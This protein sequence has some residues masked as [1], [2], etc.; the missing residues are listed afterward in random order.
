M[1]GSGGGTGVA[2]RASSELNRCDFSLAISFCRWLMLALI[3]LTLS[4]S[5]LSSPISIFSFSSWI[6]SRP[7]TICFSRSVIAG[8]F[9]TFWRMLGRGTPASTGDP[10]QLSFPVQQLQ[11]FALRQV[12]GLLVFR[13]FFTWPCSL[14]QQVHC[15]SQE[16]QMFL[17]VPRTSILREHFTQNSGF[18]ISVIL[19]C[20]FYRNR[21]TVSSAKVLLII[22]LLGRGFTASPSAGE[23]GG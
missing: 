11:P 20:K 16:A 12:R 4:A 9:R 17:S 6:G 2:F 15:S 7:R 14:I 19:T 3:V 1:T 18:S 23:M 8:E 5:L 10:P 21:E 13:L 22:F